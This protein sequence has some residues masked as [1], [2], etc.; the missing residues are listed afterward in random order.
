M[1]AA[2]GRDDKDKLKSKDK[3]QRLEQEHSELLTTS[4]RLIREMQALAK[5]AHKIVA[6]H[7]EKISAARAR[8]KKLRH[9]PF[10]HPFF[11]RFFASALPTSASQL[12]R[13]LSRSGFGPVFVLGFAGYISAKGLIP[14]S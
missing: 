11:G 5:H 14:F 2:M 3:A 6:E 9:H 8:L 13:S 1:L 10:G 7:A 4:E 12:P